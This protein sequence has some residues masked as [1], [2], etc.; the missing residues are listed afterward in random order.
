MAKQKK[1]VTKVKKGLD[2]DA[3]EFNMDVVPEVAPEPITEKPKTV[4]PKVKKEITTP[5]QSTAPPTKKEKSVYGRKS[6]VLNE[7]DRERVTITLSK[8]VVR[9]MKRDLIDNDGLLE[10]LGNHVSRSHLIELA[11]VDYLDK[12]KE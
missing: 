8:Q 6:H 9:R 12:F 1:K 7:G 10:S 2:I 11:L 4:I 3:M 5:V